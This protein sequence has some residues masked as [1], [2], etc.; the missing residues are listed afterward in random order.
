M[1]PVNWSGDGVVLDQDEA[2]DALLCLGF[3]PS[4]A[5]VIADHCRREADVWDELAARYSD[6]DPAMKAKREEIG[7][8]LR[9]RARKWVEFAALLADDGEDGRP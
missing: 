3:L 8:W 1:T 5:M 2:M 7:G 9:R 4:E 6:D